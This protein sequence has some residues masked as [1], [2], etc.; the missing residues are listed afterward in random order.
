ML[1]HLFLQMLTGIGLASLFI[2]FTLWLTCLEAEPLMREAARTPVQLVAI[3][4]GETMPFA[5]GFVATSLC[6]GRA[7]PP[8]GGT[9]NTLAT[10]NSRWG[11]RSGGSSGGISGLSSGGVSGCGRSSG[12]GGSYSGPPGGSGTSSGRDGGMLG[13]TLPGGA[14]G[15]SGTPERRRRSADEGW[16]VV[17]RL[18]MGSSKSCGCLETG[19]TC[20]ATSQLSAER[21]RRW[22]T[23]TFFDGA[24]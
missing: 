24:G 20:G 4:L 10:D 19:M 8:G 23:V 6:L 5:L 15:E 2:C 18:F 9:N 17:L 1:R 16:C 12:P 13:G 21:H 3:W 22:M 7:P 14:G 11:T